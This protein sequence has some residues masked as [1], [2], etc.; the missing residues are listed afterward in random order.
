MAYA[1]GISWVNPDIKEI[2]VRH[3]LVYDYNSMYPSVMLAY[4]YPVGTPVR[5]YNTPPKEHDL[6]IARAYVDIKRKPGKPN[7]GDKGWQI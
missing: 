1:G 6:Y 7:Q 5:W 3:G 2:E 4:P